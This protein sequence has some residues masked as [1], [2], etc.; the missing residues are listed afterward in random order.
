M[1]FF[2]CMHG[3]KLLATSRRFAIVIR[4]GKGSFKLGFSRVWLLGVGSMSSQRPLFKLES[5][6]GS[7]WRDE[8][9]SSTNQLQQTLLQAVEVMENS[10][11]SS[12]RGNSSGSQPANQSLTTSCPTVPTRLN[13]LV[14][15]LRNVLIGL[16]KCRLI[17][18]KNES[19]E[20]LIIHIKRRYKHG[21]TSL[22]V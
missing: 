14:L 20:S 18:V 5:Q 19:L 7:G 1:H 16:P 17:W 10:N 4:I 22:C 21:H 12:L 11:N 6:S 9:I 13:Q 15:V 3:R 8:V 2:S